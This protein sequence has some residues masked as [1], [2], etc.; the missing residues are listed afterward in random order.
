MEIIVNPP[1][2]IKIVCLAILIFVLCLA[3]Y[4]LC[5]SKEDTSVTSCPSPENSTEDESMVGINLE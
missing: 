1:H 4:Q 2:T 5:K 3:F